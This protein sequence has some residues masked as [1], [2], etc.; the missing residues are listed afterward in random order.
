MRTRNYFR[1]ISLFFSFLLPLLAN[2][3]E[4]TTH[5]NEQTYQL[6][7]RYNQAILKIPAYNDYESGMAAAKKA[8]KPAL[9]Y[10]NGHGSLGNRYVD[11]RILA[12][13]EIKSIIESNFQLIVL[14]V[15]D[16]T[17]LPP[18]KRIKSK[19]L[20]RIMQTVGDFNI[21]LQIAQFGDNRQPMFFIVDPKG[22][23]MI[24][25]ILTLNPG[26]FLRFLRKNN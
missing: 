8:S 25:S 6:V 4:D 23:K 10:F 13:P 12:K 21:D 9:V 18:G 2:A 3:Q 19:H 26:P 14:T 11:E 17:M 15:D 16:R 7:G 24:D 5:R 22:N 1:L 20:N